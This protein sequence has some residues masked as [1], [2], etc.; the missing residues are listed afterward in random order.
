MR[1]VLMHGLLLTLWLAVPAVA[2]EINQPPPCPEV[3][4]IAVAPP[5]EPL[6]EP[7][8]PPPLPQHQGVVLAVLATERPYRPE[9]RLLA[10]SEG[11]EYLA[12]RVRLENQGADA[13]RFNALNFQ[14]QTHDAARWNPSL[15]RRMPDLSGGE[16]PPG[17]AVEGWLVFEVPSALTVTDLLWT[18][19]LRETYWV[20]LAP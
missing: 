15:G 5:T 20:P 18:P 12:L 13:R 7:P 11:R 4:P 16:I 1:W 19:E 6:A 10:P 8:A 9:G 17:A 2:Q 14:V 3:A